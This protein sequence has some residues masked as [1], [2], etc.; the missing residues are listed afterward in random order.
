MNVLSAL[1][2]LVLLVTA[3]VALIPELTFGLALVFMAGIFFVWLLPILIIADLEKTTGG[4]KAA[5]ILTIIILSRF[6]WIF[7]FLLAPIKPKSY[8]RY[9]SSDRY[10]YN[11]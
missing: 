3:G 4:E 8:R 6:T 7:Y 11:D 9:Y 2:I 5:W 1:I 10:D